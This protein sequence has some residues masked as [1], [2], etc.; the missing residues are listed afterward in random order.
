M[1]GVQVFRTWSLFSCLEEKPLS[2]QRVDS[3]ERFL[4]RLLGLGKEGEDLKAL[5]ILHF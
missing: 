4:F 2:S 1:L 5:V 3:E